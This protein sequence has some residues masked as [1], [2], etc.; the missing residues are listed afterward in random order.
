M[1]RE[2]KKEKF[3][4]RRP[5]TDR[6]TDWTDVHRKRAS[7][8]GKN[9]VGARRSDFFLFRSLLPWVLSR[10]MNACARNT[11]LC[12][13]VCC[14]FSLFFFGFFERFSLQNLPLFPERIFFIR[15]KTSE[16][17]REEEARKS[18]F[19]RERERKK[20]LERAPAGGR[21]LP[22]K[23]PTPSREI[24][25]GAFFTLLPRGASFPQNNLARERELDIPLSFSLARRRRVRTTAFI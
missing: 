7:D 19:G 25:R 17:S 21:P 9:K 2:R 12:V 23:N 24:N 11:A 18:S 3:T 8:K 22:S 16:S 13:S 15:D 14:R 4:G 10:G 5:T 20:F 6:R 1:N